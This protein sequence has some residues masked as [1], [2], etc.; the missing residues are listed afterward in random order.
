ML[1]SGLAAVAACTG[2]NGAPLA[3]NEA[4]AQSEPRS[5]LG[6]VMGAPQDGEAGV[7]VRRVVRGSPAEKGGLRAGDRLVRVDA[8]VVKHP[9]DVSRVVGAHPAG[10]RLAVDLVRGGK[11][12]RLAI[13]LEPAPTSDD[14]LRLD[15]VGT[16]APDFTAL[17]AIRGTVPTAPSALRGRV[18]VLEFWATWCGACRYVAP[19]VA[20]WQARYGAQGLSVLG[21]AAEETARVATH[22][23]REEPPYAIAADPSGET[24]LAYGVTSLPTLFVIDKRGVVRFVEVGASPGRLALLERELQALLAEPAPKDSEE[25]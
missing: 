25:K 24:S 4:H 12:M 15:R 22:V 6:I 14:V 19:T 21:I 16:F 3:P 7:A 2:G 17:D 11:P 20:R 10:G 23:A 9:A 5:W 8:T 1:V 13:A 18:V